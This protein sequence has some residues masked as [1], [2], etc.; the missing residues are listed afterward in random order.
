M[1]INKRNFALSLFLFSVYGYTAEFV[2]I[3]SS[4][5]NLYFSS[6]KAKW[7]QTEDKNT[8]YVLVN[9]ITLPNGVKKNK[10]VQYYNGIPV[11]S[12]LLTNS[13]IGDK[14]KN[15]WGGFLKNIHQDLKSTIPKLSNQD[16]LL[17]VQKHFN[18]EH[19]QITDEQAQL[20]IK[21]NVNT[22]KAE[23]VYWVSYLNETNAKVTRPNAFVNA[24][25]GKIIDAW[26]G[27]TSKDAYGPGGNEK[28]GKYY[29]GKDGLSPLIVNDS[30]QMNTSN[31]DTYDMKNQ[32]NGDGTLFQFKCPENT[33]KQINGAYSPINDAHYF[34]NIVFDMYRTIFNI[35]PLKTKLK[36]RVHY[37]N[38]FENAFWDGK[39]MT[40]GDGG[41]NLYPMTSL[42]VVGHEVSHGVTEQNSGLIY[43]GQSGGINEAFSDMAGEM[44]EFYMANQIGK[45]NDWLVGHSI[46]K[47]PYGTAM[48]YFEDPT[49]DGRSIGHAKDYKDS[50]DVHFTSG[51]Y[52]K[53]FYLLAHRT[54]WGI[55]K[56]FQVFL[57]ANQVYWK[58]DETFNNAACGVNKAATDLGYDVADVVASFEAVGVNA[59]CSS[60]LP[61]PGPDDGDKTE[62]EVKNGQIVADIKV[63]EDSQHRYYID[64]PTLPRYPYAYKMLRI[65]LFNTTGTSRE[66]ADIYIGYDTLPQKIIQATQNNDEFFD[67][68]F[69]DA[70]RYHILI[71]GKKTGIINLQ[72]YYIS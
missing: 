44:S 21:Q 5:I 47:G 69:P 26:D 23:L 45:E 61:N 31:V 43:K 39:Q 63:S 4:N 24:N 40:F 25:T 71:K 68:K 16:V 20:Y 35:A 60:P 19:Q 42:D 72:A 17:I 58:N 51:V 2:S 18:D 11:F 48:R 6:H 22:Q 12:L 37:G 32:T 65:R 8:D 70:G 9:T 64:V 14:H 29:Y 50:L 1:L 15:W 56:A 57:L 59:Q 10:F 36:L 33:Y 27:L 66:F 28:I 53:A 46:I 13:Q 7:L 34:G 62:L 55:Q 54:N 30:C 38:S 41:S 67:I 49:K 3:D 52:N